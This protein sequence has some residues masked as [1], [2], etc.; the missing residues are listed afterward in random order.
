MI[1]VGAIALLKTFLMQ[2]AVKGL[3]RP[4]LA[5]SLQ[6]VGLVPNPPGVGLDTRI[7]RLHQAV[8]RVEASLDHDRLAKLSGAFKLLNKA[9]R[10]SRRESLLQEVVG[11]LH[12]I[13][14]LPTS[15]T[16]AGWPNR[17]LKALAQ[18]GLAQ[19]HYLCDDDDDLIAEHLS[20]SLLL[21]KNAAA[22]LLGGALPPELDAQL[23]SLRASMPAT[24]A[25]P[26]RPPEATIV[27]LPGHRVQLR[28]PLVGGVSRCGRSMRVAVTLDELELWLRARAGD[29]IIMDPPA[30]SDTIN[31]HQ[32]VVRGQAKDGLVEEKGR[33]NALRN[34]KGRKSWQIEGEIE[35]QI[36]ASLNNWPLVT[37]VCVSDKAGIPLHQWECG[38][39]VFSY[40]ER[41]VVY[42]CM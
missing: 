13:A 23:E 18:L 42:S 36:S 28:L 11:R 12:E 24:A 9:S 26:P 14:E 2:E 39:W 37:E 7:D 35:R 4:W 27:Q 32:I 5:K 33:A 38:E 31:D 1:E 8:E 16:T 21:D 25:P 6:R 29:G 10:A 3:V 34:Q 22:D 15:G 40:Q 19:Y 20:E 30:F 17:E 41:A